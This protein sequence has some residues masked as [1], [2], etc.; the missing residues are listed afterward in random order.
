MQSI[1][2]EQCDKF[3]STPTV[4]PLTGRKIAIG[5]VTHAKLT[6]LCNTA[7]TKPKPKSTKKTKNVYI[8]PLGPMM[9]WSIDGIYGNGQDQKNAYEFIK[10]LKEKYFE[11]KDN[12]VREISKSEILDYI[13]MSDDLSNMDRLSTQLNQYSASLREKFKELKKTMKLINDQPK[14]DVFEYNGR[15]VMEIRPSRTFNRAQVADVYNFYMQI[16]KSLKSE[17]LKKT[18]TVIPRSHV[19][20]DQKRHK[21]YLDHL[22]KLNV[23]SYDDIYKHTFKNEKFP[24]ELEAL[25]KR[26]LDKYPSEK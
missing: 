15:A 14:H 25:Y 8:P 23:F 20:G 10:F 17:I 7:T 11:L 26:Y 19:L 9:H 3:K 18:N 13:E 24:E 12:N 6:K 5:K 22:I 2:K 21:A 1:T 16:M 4:N